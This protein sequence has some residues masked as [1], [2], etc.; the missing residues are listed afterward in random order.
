MLNLTHWSLFANY[1]IHISN[2][3]FVVYH[4]YMVLS[5]LKTAFLFNTVYERP[6]TKLLDICL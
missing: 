5:R 1:E 3:C 2:S 4:R 6:V